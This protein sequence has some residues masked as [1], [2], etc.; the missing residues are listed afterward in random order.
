MDEY[1]L[2]LWDDSDLLAAVKKWEA[3]RAELKGCWRPPMSENVTWDDCAAE[4]REF[5]H[6]RAQMSARLPGGNKQYA[7]N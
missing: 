6:K 2:V 7:R 5:L 4:F 3:T 1:L